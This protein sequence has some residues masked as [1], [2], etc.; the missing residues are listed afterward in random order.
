MAAMKREPCYA[1]GYAALNTS[2]D[3]RIYTTLDLQ[4]QRAAQNAVDWVEPLN[5][6]AFNPG[7]NVDTEVGIQPGTGRGRAIAV[8]RLY[9]THQGLGQTAGHYA[10]E[11]QY[12][13]GAGVQT[14]AS[15]RRVRPRPALK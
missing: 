13:G 14:A 1:R 6:G 5:S 12:A 3:L 2:G 11:S 15:G 9:G 7:G 4:D 8:D 10:G